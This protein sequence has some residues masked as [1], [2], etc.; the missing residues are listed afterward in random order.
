MAEFIHH[1]FNNV[2]L[3][4]D[5]CL[6]EERVQCS[7]T[8]LVLIEVNGMERSCRRPK[9]FHR[10]IIFVP[11]CVMAVKLFIEGRVADVKFMRTYPDDR[12]CCK[13]VLPSQSNDRA[14][15]HHISGASQQF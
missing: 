2:I 5:V 8:T 6:G 10:P 12:A 9:C 15:A 11:S 1:C 4:N 13:L 3:V 14:M 7:A